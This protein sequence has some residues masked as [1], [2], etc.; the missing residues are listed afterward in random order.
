MQVRDPDEVHIDPPGGTNLLGS[1]VISRLEA[2]CT[3]DSERSLA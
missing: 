2:L 1:Y 3:F